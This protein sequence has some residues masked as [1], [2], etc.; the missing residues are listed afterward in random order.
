MVAAL[1]ETT[2]MLPP[3]A[4]V[5]LRDKMLKDKIGRRILKEKPVINSSTVDIMALRRLPDGSFGREY[6][7]FLDDQKVSPDTRVK[8]HF[9]DDEELAYVMQRF[10]ECHDFFHTLTNLSTTV[11]AE[12]ALKWFEMIQTGLPVTTISSFFGHF[13]LTYKE[14]KRLFEK[15]VPWALQCGFQSKLLLNVYFEECWDM[16]LDQLRK[17]LGI[18]AME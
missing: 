13:S 4:L 15:Y 9:I 7:R 11:E 12:L 17:D 2:S 16:K 10:R 1:G 5:S 18:L 14:R 6:V 8:V 3:F